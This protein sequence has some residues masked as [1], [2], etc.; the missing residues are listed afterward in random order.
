MR[1]TFSLGLST[2]ALPQAMARGYIHM[3]T[4]AGKLKGVMP[5]QTPKGSRMVIPSTS[6]AR[7]GRF[8]PLARC[9]MPQANSTTSTPRRRSPRA[10]SRVLPFSVAMSRLS[11]SKW[12]SSNSR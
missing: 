6:S 1:G 12:A 11:S 9:E 4:M 10:S 8:S 5:A 7:R 2:K 3:G